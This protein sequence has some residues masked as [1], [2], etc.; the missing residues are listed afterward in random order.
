MSQ[1]VTAA[2]LEQIARAA[3][4]ACAGAPLTEA[5]LVGSPGRP[6]I[7]GAGKAVGAMAAGARR[8]LGA[9]F[10]HGPL[11]GKHGGEAGLEVTAAGHP[12]PD[13]R[14]VRATHELLAFVGA[15]GAEE[16]LVLLLSGGASALLAATVEGV[17]LPGLIAATSELSRQGAPIAA[18]NCVRRHLGLALGGR[19]AHATPARLRVLALSDV[20]GDDPATIG[21]GPASP[22]PTTVEDAR[23]VARAYGLRGEVRDLLERGAIPETPKP[24]D[25]RLARVEYRLLATPRSLREHAVLEARAAGY[26]PRVE[27]ALVT[28][29]VEAVAAR[30]LALADQLAQGEL[31]VAVGEPTV[32]VRGAGVGGRAQHLAL[33]VARALAGRPYAFLAIGSDGTDGPTDAAGALVDGSTWQSARSLGLDPEGALARFDAGPLLD[34]T[35]ALLRTGPTGTNL[36]DLHLLAALGP[37]SRCR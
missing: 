31:L 2:G 24:G 18:I 4:A 13:E 10:R 3:I 29:E 34:A 7:V 26:A 16:E 25:E 15:L 12:L 21:S 1:R 28:G 11:V 5:A 23:A 35:G 36:C 33:L 8:A 19:L 27:E 20:A 14:G 32:R 6:W 17:S 30:Y 9:R 37:A 22:D